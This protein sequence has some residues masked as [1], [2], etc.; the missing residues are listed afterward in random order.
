VQDLKGPP[1]CP[2]GVDLALIGSGEQLDLLLLQGGSL[3]TAALHHLAHVAHHVVV[4]LCL[5]C[6]LGELDRFQPLSAHN[7][8]SLPCPHCHPRLQHLLSLL[9]SERSAHLSDLR[10]LE[11]TF[12]QIAAE[13]DAQLAACEDTRVAIVK[14]LEQY[15]Q[16]NVKLSEKVKQQA[17][18]IKALTARQLSLECD[19][20]R[21]QETGEK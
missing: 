1:G 7:N 9:D 4:P 6:D 20:L 5:L 13:K 15:K 18:T 8:M 10:A 12:Q 17:D 11:E 21:T 3:P 14:K 16:R 2:A 19:V